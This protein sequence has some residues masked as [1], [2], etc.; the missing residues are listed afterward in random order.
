MGLP[1]LRVAVS[2]PSMAPTLADGE[3]WIALRGSEIRDGD[4]VVVEGLGDAP[5]LAVKRAVRRE[6]GGWWLE[7]DNAGVS[8]DSRHFGAVPDQA[9]VGRLLLRYRPLPLRR[10]CHLGG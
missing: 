1:L 6:A 4:L 2:G 7:G 9:I 10:A 8:R 5:G 3:W